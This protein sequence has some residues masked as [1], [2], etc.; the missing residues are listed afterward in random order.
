SIDIVNVYNVFDKNFSQK[1]Q[2]V[3]LNCGESPQSINEHIDRLVRFLSIEGIRGRL[4]IL[5]PD[6]D[7][8]DRQRIVSHYEDFY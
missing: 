7:I 5:N 4:Q 1:M 3:L 8:Q 6:I 2:T